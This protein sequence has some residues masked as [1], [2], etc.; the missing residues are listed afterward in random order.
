VSPLAASGVDTTLSASFR[1][2]GPTQPRHQNSR[3]N[4]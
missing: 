1:A 2:A 4:S 3:E